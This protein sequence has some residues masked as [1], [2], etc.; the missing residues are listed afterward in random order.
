MIALIA[1]GL[2]AGTA[3]SIP[4]QHFIFGSGSRWVVLDDAG[5]IVRRIDALPTGMPDEAREAAV[6]L[7]GTKIVWAAADQNAQNVMLFLWDTV[8]N[9][10]RRV[11]DQEGFHAA[12]AFAP[13]GKSITFA[14]HPRKGGPPGMHQEGSYAAL[15][16]QDLETWV[17]RAR[18][19]EPGCHMESSSTPDAIYFAHAD[20]LGGRR[21]EVL[22]DGKATPLT[23]FAE[24][25]GE[26][27]I[28]V[29]GRTL[30]ATRRTGDDVEILKFSVSKP[31]VK[32]TLWRGR[33]IGSSLRPALLRSGDLVFQVGRNVLRLPSGASPDT[34]PVVIAELGG[35]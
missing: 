12:P 13:S 34:K 6:S 22:Q 32:T 5:R 7:D 30:V 31:N 19:D 3:S 20:C 25:H 9:T 16:E 29:D 2:V 17:L 14:H 8:A 11:G 24:H 26:P 28:S 10:A 1:A 18:T 21:I 33:G 15:Y 35:R 27:R 23:D 4:A